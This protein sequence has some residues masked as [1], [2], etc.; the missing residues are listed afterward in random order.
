MTFDTAPTPGAP[1]FRLSY[2]LSRPKT[3]AIAFSM[4]PPGGADFHP[5]AT[6][7]AVKGP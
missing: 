3:L 4:A 2:T 1:A 7:S 6:G 5:I